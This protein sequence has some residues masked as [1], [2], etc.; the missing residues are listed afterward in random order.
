MQSELL[1]LINPF[2]L[3]FIYKKK[4]YTNVHL[5]RKSTQPHSAAPVG[6]SGFQSHVHLFHWTCDGGTK[7]RRGFR[8][9]IMGTDKT[10]L[11]EYGGVVF[12][13]TLC[14][15]CQ[16]WQLLLSVGDVCSISGLFRKF[17]HWCEADTVRIPLCR[18]QLTSHCISDVN[19]ADVGTLS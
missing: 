2:R 17:T 15:Y 8:I 10:N 5:G 13:L 7:P 18:S 16:L 1:H 11:R 12:K 19:Y 14:L 6:L 4:K 3:H 9:S